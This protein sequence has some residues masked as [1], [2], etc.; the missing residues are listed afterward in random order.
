VRVELTLL[1]A[2]LTGAACGEGGAGADAGLDAGAADAAAADAE[3][4]AG[5]ADAE[6]PDAGEL[7]LTTL[8]SPADLLRMQGSKTHVKYLGQVEGAPIR[9]PIVERCYFQNME[10]H[11]FHLLFLRAF[12]ETATMTPDEYVALVLRRPTRIWWGGGLQRL[13]R[14][15]P[16]S[17]ELEV[18][19]YTIYAETAGPSMLQ[20]DDV[21]EVDQMMRQCAP[22]ATRL[23]AFLPS[24]PFQVTF[25]RANQTEL[26]AA[27]VAVVFP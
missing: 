20:R 2:L 21:V 18:L 22:Y 3:L 10:R 1:A 23:L 11:E 26:E 12:T 6:G 13:Q 15:H 14:V 7:Y 24:D 27:G 8:D 17:G 16:I 5:S 9:P 4:D 25:A 19:A